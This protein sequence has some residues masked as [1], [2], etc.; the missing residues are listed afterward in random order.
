[1]ISIET[2]SELLQTLYSAP[3]EQSQWQRFLTALSQHTRSSSG[4][5]LSA[6]EQ[7]QL[8]ALASGGALN[9]EPL[10]AI[11]NDKFAATDPFRIAAA[12]MA[13]TRN[14]VGVYTENELLPDNGVL[15]TP[16]YRELLLQAK[17][18]Y[19][20]MIIL[21]L[22]VRRL[23]AISLWRTAEEGP[24]DGDSRHLLE[25]LLPHVQTALEVHRRLKLSDQHQANAQAMADASP[26]ATFVLDAHGH[27]QHCNAAAEALVRMGDG[28]KV[29]NGRLSSSTMSS[30]DALGRL[31][32]N[33]AVACTPFAAET[34]LHALSLQRQGA[35]RPLQLI[36]SPLPDHQRARL[37]GDVL[38]VITDPDTTVTFPDSVLH[39]LYGFSPAEVETAN[40][41]LLGYGLN[42]IA[43][44]RRVSLGTVRQ[45]IKSMMAK[46][47][48]SRQADLIRLLMTLPRAF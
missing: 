44:L 20:A 1:M 48:T 8:A 4:F 39:A 31:I 7:L 32:K 22:S 13:R 28:V 47:D 18:R 45:Q 26:V 9:R 12:R 19:A 27:L 40:G 2:F 21:T 37:G 10:I 46:A 6:D 42:E 15:R 14:P 36:A 34:G 38:M 16:L 23:D 11:Y 25:L 5:F 24:V 17:L 30:D 35:K 3:L 29:K 43:C 33:A 41:L